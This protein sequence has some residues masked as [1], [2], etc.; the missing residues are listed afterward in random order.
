MT[1]RVLRR[2]FTLVELLVV[3]A[4][5]GILVALLLPA[6][7]AA[8]EAARRSQCSNNLKQLGL[9]VHNYHD[10]YKKIPCSFDWNGPKNGWLPSLLPFVEQ[11]A[12]YDVLAQ[13]NFQLGAAGCKPVREAVLDV[14]RCPSD[15]LSERIKTDQFQWS[16]TPMAVTNYKGVIGDPNMGN[17]WPG[18]GSADTHNVS[19][20][21]GMF[22]R[23]SFRGAYSFAGITDGLSNTLMIGEDIP[24]HNNHSAWSYSNGD[25]CSCHAP[26]KFMPKPP[27]PNNWPRVMGFRSLH[28]G[29][30][31][32]SKADGSVQTVAQT[33]DH[34]VYRA[35]CTRG[36]GESTSLP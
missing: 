33:V 27:D 20:N 17:G 31:Q 22:W 2:G 10:T 15:G 35:A 24:Y 19:P 30:V 11:P 7:Q 26:L 13:N 6:V 28:P 14:L 21:N 5:I 16:G 4:I 34:N 23:E 25:Y 18:M 32:F 12:L 3:I 9:A 29:I 1:V 8:R 36:G